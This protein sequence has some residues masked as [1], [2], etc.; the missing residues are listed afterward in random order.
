MTMREKLYAYSPDELKAIIGKFTGS[1][2]ER[3]YYRLGPNGEHIP[4]ID[5]TSVDTRR[6]STPAEKSIL[7][8]L[9]RSA[10]YTIRM[11]GDVQTA[12]NTVELAADMMIENLNG[13][14]SIYLPLR[15]ILRVASENG[16]EE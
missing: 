15:K 8:N 16:E 11:G 6:P 7:E 10:L 3:T 2:V 9:M 1:L 12:L 4:D 13:Y 14:D 5:G